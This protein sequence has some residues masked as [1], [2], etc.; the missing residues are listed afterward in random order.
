MGYD[1]EMWTLGPL[2]RYNFRAVPENQRE[3]EEP[4]ELVGAS[5]DMVR[6]RRQR[7]MR[8]EERPEG[9]L[10]WRARI[11]KEGRHRTP[12]LASQTVGPLLIGD[13]C[14]ALSL[15]ETQFHHV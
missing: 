15:S 6:V 7:Q 8:R 3:G 14:R 2:G 9:G 4:E 13:V 5:V 12:A 1:V 10:L 11:D